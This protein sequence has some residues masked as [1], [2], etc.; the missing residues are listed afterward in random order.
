MT[1]P[2]ASALVRSPLLG[3]AV[4]RA[5]PH[6]GAVYSRA[7]T[8]DETATLLAAARRGLQ[9]PEDVADMVRAAGGGW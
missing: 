1:P 6:C 3:L 9:V 2:D 4:R 7:L 8:R 5:C